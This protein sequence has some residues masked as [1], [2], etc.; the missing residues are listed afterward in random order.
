MLYQVWNICFL[1]KIHF[2][3]LCV[4]DKKAFRNSSFYPCSFACSY[5]WHLYEKD[6]CCLGADI[7][8]DLCSAQDILTL[9]LEL[10]PIQILAKALLL[11]IPCVNESF[12][13]HTRTI[14]PIRR[15]RGPPGPNFYSTPCTSSSGFVPS[16]ILWEEGISRSWKAKWTISFKSH[17]LLKKQDMK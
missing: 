11:I 3:I 16:Y 12:V 10:N 6:K 5:S 14:K 1:K 8:V 15:F 7:R 17:I 9:T 4:P 2:V 13:G